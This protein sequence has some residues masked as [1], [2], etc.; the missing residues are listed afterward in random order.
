MRLTDLERQGATL[1]TLVADPTVEQAI[2]KR[3]THGNF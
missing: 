3:D 2:R 1:M